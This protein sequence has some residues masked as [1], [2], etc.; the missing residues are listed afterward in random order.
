M[1][2]AKQAGKGRRS[3]IAYGESAG[4]TL[5][6][7]LAQKGLVDAAAVQSPVVDIPSWLAG[8]DLEPASL[9]ALLSL[10]PETA[11]L[12]SPDQ[13]R[14]TSPI[15]A[16]I[17]ADDAISAPAAPWAKKAKKV[18]GATVPGTHLDPRFQPARLKMAM[19][20]LAHH[21]PTATPPT[22]VVGRAANG[23]PTAAV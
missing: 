10:T 23:Q 14:A 13:H 17:A 4:G 22:V 3:V 12:Y 1:S 9:L 15:F 6:I 19:N 18:T 11:L 5:A 20:F 8:I 7:L 16:E 21:L 2:A